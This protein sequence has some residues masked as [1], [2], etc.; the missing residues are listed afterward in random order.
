DEFSALNGIAADADRG[1]LAE[2][3]ATR[4]EYRFIGKSA[5]A[6]HNSN[7]A[8][9]EN[10]ARHDANLGFAR[11]HHART[12]GPNQSRLRASKLALDHV[13]YGNALSNADDQRDLRLDRLA[14]G[15]ASASRRHIDHACITTS[16]LLGLGN[17][18]EHRQVEMCRA[19]FTG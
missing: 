18:V 7:F 17:S 14:N 11:G 2:I 4:L 15:I 5:G 6:R 9:L 3:L 16:F 8:G 10:V 13:Q 19:A 12:V 1:R